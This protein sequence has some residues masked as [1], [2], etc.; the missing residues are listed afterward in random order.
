LRGGP[1]K[2]GASRR[3]PGGN[4][5][6]EGHVLV[7]RV[8]VVRGAGIVAGQCVIEV[9]EFQVQVGRLQVAELVLNPCGLIPGPQAVAQVVPG[10][11]IR[12]GLE[13]AAERRLEDDQRPVRGLGG[14]DGGRGG[15]FHADDDTGQ[16]RRR[17]RG[18][19]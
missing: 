18:G 2:R 3:R 5:R 12:G 19:D 10:E 7:Q 17:G 15:G 14:G 8:A 13:A 16:V 11:L 9:V 4:R 1:G 6:R